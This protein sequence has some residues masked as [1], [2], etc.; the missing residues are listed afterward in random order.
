M[1]TKSYNIGR[2]QCIIGGF[3][4]Q[5]LGDDGGFSFEPSEDQIIGS[6]G[7]DGEATISRSN[8]KSG[9]LTVTLKET[10]DSNQILEDFLNAQDVG[11]GLAYNVP[12]QLYDP[13]TGEGVTSRESAIM[14]YPTRSKNKE[15]SEREWTIWIPRFVATS[16]GSLV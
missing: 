13:S 3:R 9:T 14:G 5:G 1:G 15:A 10:S 2:V 16:A 12:V 8:N 11:T 4:M 7:A 6:V